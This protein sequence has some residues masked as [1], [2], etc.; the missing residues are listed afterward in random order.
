[1]DEHTLKERHPNTYRYLL[2]FKEKLTRRR[3][4][5]KFYAKGNQWFRF[6]RPGRWT[7]ITKEKLLIRGLAKVSCVGYL[8]KN[9]AF[10]G[11]NCPALILDGADPITIMGILNSSLITYYL[12][13]ICPPKLQGYRRFNANNL[14]RIPIPQGREDLLSRIS[15]LAQELMELCAIEEQKMTPFETEKVERQTRY[16]KNETDELVFDLYSLSAKD[17][18]VVL[19]E[20]KSFSN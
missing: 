19:A 20:I 2:Q 9:T 1:M 10:N 13:S 12:R 3:D 5:R 15:K 8:A 16:K 4:S 11:A 17:K 18:D 7:Y 6:L 14:N